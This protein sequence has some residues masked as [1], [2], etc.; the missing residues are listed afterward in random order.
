MSRSRNR[1]LQELF[2]R[3]VAIHHAGML[4]SDRNL[5]ERLFSRGVVRVLCCTAT[6]AWGVNL[7]AHTVV[8][9]GTQMYDPQQGCFTEVGMLDVQQIFGR[10]GRPQYN[11]PGVGIIITT[12]DKLARYLGMLTHSAPIE[13]HFE[14]GLVDNLNAEVVL[15]TVTNVREACTWLSYTYMHTRMTKNPLAYGVTW[16]ELQSDP[17]LELHRRRMVER[18]AKELDRSRMVRFDERSGNLYVTELGRVA[19]HYYVRHKT[20]VEF[21]E[22]LRPQMSEAEVLDLIA[23]SAEFEQMNVRRGAWARGCDTRRGLRVNGDAQR[24][25]AQ[26]C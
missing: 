12:H 18:A 22:R 17:G 15:G 19:S 8:I 20:V 4:R 11:I 5:V 26:H 3:G 1:E 21:N 7:P 25:T 6:L 2:D 13:S 9:K 23:S 14:K 10:A 24:V 16:E